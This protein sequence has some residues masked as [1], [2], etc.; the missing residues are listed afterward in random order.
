MLKPVAVAA[1]LTL[2]A[3]PPALAVFSGDMSARARSGDEDYAQG[4]D[5]FEAQDWPGVIEAMLR[6]VARRP[7][8][9]NAHTYLGFA[10]RKTGDYDSALKHYVLALERHPR[11]RRALSYLG[12]A[13]LQLD[14]PEKAAEVLDRLHEVCLSVA[15]SFSDGDFTNGCDEYT[16]LK[17]SYDFYV[18]HG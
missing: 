9:D 16:A 12:E 1:A 3:V 5:A 8:H 15:I 17:D 10:Y 13:Y 6:V 18:E 11:N 7:W 14:A 4:K 2:A